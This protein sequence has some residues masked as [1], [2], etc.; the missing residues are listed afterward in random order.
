MKWFNER[1]TL[2]VF[3]QNDRSQLS[4]DI[5]KPDSVV[6]DSNLSENN[7]NLSSLLSAASPSTISLT[8]TPPIL[9]QI[10]CSTSVS[11]MLNSTTPKTEVKTEPSADIKSESDIKE[12]KMEVKSEADCKPDIQ[13]VKDE[14]DTSSPKLDNMDE[15][16]Q[17]SEDK[18]LSVGDSS[19]NASAGTPK[20]RCKKGI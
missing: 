2:V 20:P 8:I 11:S 18:P 3:P 7:H 12:E 1:F 9:P 13:S 16:S 10:T 4:D 19:N 5:N 15:N 17:A 6:K 14:N